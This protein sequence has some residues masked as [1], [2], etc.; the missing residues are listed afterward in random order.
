MA[1][2]CTGKG[3]GNRIPGAAPNVCSNK[4]GGKSIVIGFD[5]HKE[6]DIAIP[7]YVIAF[8]ATQQILV[9]DVDLELA[10]KIRKTRLEDFKGDLYGS[11]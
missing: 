3:S 11:F 2:V 5:Y 10:R 6:S 8:S 7:K 1:Y 4:Y 9:M